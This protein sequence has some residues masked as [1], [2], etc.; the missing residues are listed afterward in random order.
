VGQSGASGTI[1]N[2][3]QFIIDQMLAVG[4]L[5]STVFALGVIFAIKF[6]WMQRERIKDF[7]WYILAFISLPTIIPAIYTF[8]QSAS[9][10]G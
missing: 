10:G 3:L 1:N 6:G 8:S 4:A 2:I 5:L 9:A 7:I